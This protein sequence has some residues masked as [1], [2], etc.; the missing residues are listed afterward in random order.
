MSALTAEN[1]NE[2]VRSE[3]CFAVVEAVQEFRGK[4]LNVEEIETRGTGE[5]NLEN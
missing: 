4:Q 5:R 3:I 2:N 1:T